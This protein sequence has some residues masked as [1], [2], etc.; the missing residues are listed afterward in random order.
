MKIEI[1]PLESD[2]DY[3]AVEQLQRDIWGTPEIEITPGDLM[4]VAARNGGV[5]LGAFSEA[6]MIGFVFGFLGQR[7]DGVIKHCS[8][9]AG[10][11]SEFQNHDIGYRMK[12]AQREQVLAQGMKLITWTFDPLESRNA[13]FN[14][15]KLGVT[16]NTYLRNAYGAM[17][18]ALNKGLPSDRFQIDWL[19]ASD[20][21]AAVLAGERSRLMPSQLESEGV[22]MITRPARLTSG[23]DRLLVEIPANFQQLKAAEYGLA[24]EWRLYTRSLFEE[25]FEKRYF[26]TDLLVENG[27][28]FYLLSGPTGQS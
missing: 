24:L 12:L 1:R 19:I 2:D 5:V 21:V 22:Q 26:V 4:R 7:D 14:F 25:L 13:R 28:S 3:L 10:V 18:D 16:C 20:R 27:R 8:H 9:I 17:R 23:G 6:R 11:V 15:N